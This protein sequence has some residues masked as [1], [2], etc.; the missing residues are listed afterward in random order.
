MQRA[1]DDETWNK[2]VEMAEAPMLISIAAKEKELMDLNTYRLG[3]SI[4]IM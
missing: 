3:H 2:L 1:V 4:K